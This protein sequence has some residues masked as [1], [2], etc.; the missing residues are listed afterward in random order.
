MTVTVWDP[1]E[2]QVKATVP[3][4]HGVTSSPLAALVRNLTLPALIVCLV[5]FFVAVFSETWR[6]HG[7]GVATVGFLFITFGSELTGQNSNRRARIANAARTSGLLGGTKLPK[8]KIAKLAARIKSLLILRAGASIPIVLE[9]EVW[10]KTQAGIP[11]WMGLSLIPSQAF[12]GGPKASV[13]ADRTTTHGET[14]MFVVAYQLDRDTRIHAEMMP[15]FVTAKG[16]LD[17]D[18]KTESSE[19][20]A[21]FNIRLRAEN[22]QKTAKGVSSAALLQVLTPAAQVTLLDLADRYSARV[23]VDRDT[24]FFGGYRNF[25]TTDNTLLQALLTQAIEDFSEAAVL[26][27]TYME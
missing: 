15:E 6:F 20:N 5:G 11:F 17:R 23:I 8:P 26:F 12:F 13:R 9:H 27:K 4:E 2:G 25:Q 21:K 18:V 22:D 19:F 7:M 16:P 10:G 1:I 3:E 14:A 24:V